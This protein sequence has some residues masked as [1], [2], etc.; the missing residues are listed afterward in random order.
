MNNEEDTRRHHYMKEG[1]IFCVKN[2]RPDDHGVGGDSD[3]M[4]MR[5]CPACY[6]TV[7]ACLSRCTSCW[8]QFISCG[9]YQRNVQ[10]RESPLEVP[11]TSI[12]QTIE[13]A[14]AAVPSLDVDGVGDEQLDTVTRAEPEMEVDGPQSDAE[15]EPDEEMI[16]DLEDYEVLQIASERRPLLLP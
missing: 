4:R 3:G 1:I 2:T 13:A 10:Q 16:Q 8:L 14:T 7:P 12:A 11:S 15:P 6:T 5:I 9:K